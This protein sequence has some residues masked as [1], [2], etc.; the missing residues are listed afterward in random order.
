L[1]EALDELARV[2][3]PDGFLWISVPNGY[4]VDD[5][6]YRFLYVGGG[7]V[8]R[9]TFSGLKTAVESKTGLALLKFNILTS[10]FI[11]CKRAPAS[12][13]QYLPRRLKVLQAIGLV[14]PFAMLQLNAIFR[15]LDRLLHS[16]L[17]QYG[18]G[19]LFGRRGTTVDVSLP[20]FFNV[21]GG[22]GS[23]HAATDLKPGA[24]RRWG[25]KFYR[26]PGCSEANLL[27]DPPP[28]FD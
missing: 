2:L 3:T 22:C 8:N 10:S 7:H 19:F 9:F 20:S 17:S 4:G 12:T 28:G 6:L 11:Y 1:N 18:W 24:Y 25:F 16:S 15:W 27:F 14:G 5:R 23:G 26:C 21:C 13:W